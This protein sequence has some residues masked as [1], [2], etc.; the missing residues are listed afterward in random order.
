M[1]DASPQIGKPAVRDPATVGQLG[2]QCSGPAQPGTVLSFS[3][4]ISFA[5]AVLATWTGGERP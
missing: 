2:E 1:F 3:M 5:T 4:P